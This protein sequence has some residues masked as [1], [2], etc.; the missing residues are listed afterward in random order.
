MGETCGW[1]GKILRVDLST[2]SVTTEDTSKYVPDYIGGKGIATKIAW[3]ELK[4]GVGP[5]DPENILIFMTGPFAGTLAPTSGRGIV[6]GVSPRPYPTPWFTYGGIGGN[7]ASELKYAGFDGMAIKGNSSKPVYLWVHDGEAEIKEAEALWGTDT[8]FT[9]KS[10][11][12]EYGKKAQVLCIGPAGENRV[13]FATI[14]HRLSNAVGNAGLGAV[15]GAKKLKGIVIRGTGGVKVANPSKFL[16]ACQ[17]VTELISAGPTFKPIGSPPGP[18]SMPCTHACPLGCSAMFKN[19]PV[20]LEVGS[21]TRTMMGHCVNSMYNLGINQTEYPIKFTKDSY[22]GD[23]HTR[24]TKGFGIKIGTELQVIGEGLGL[25]GWNYL[26]MYVWFWSCIDNGVTELNGYKLDP[27]NPEFWH[28]LLHKIAYREG[29]GDILADSLRRA[30]DRLDLPEIIRKHASWQEPIWGFSTH[31]LGRGFEWQPSP[32]WIYTM[33]Q[34]IMD[35]RDP[36][37][38]NHQSSFVEFW[39]PPHYGRGSPDTDFDKLK[40]TYAR[41]FGSGEV[42]EPGFGDIDGKTKAA[43]WLNNR[44]QLKD[45][46][47]LCDWC[48]PRVLSGFKSKEELKAAKDYYGDIDAEAKLFGPLTGLD[49]STSD[50]EKA[51]ERIKNL[52]RALH[53]RNYN[54]S[55]KIDSSAEWLFEYPEKSDGTKLDMAIFDT[56]LDSYYENRGWDKTTGC[57]TRAKLEELGLKDVADKLDNLG[58]LP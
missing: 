11:K 29:I 5:Y 33:L 36:M 26:N 56:I 47:L 43:I 58:K 53:I 10:L 41:V 16:S 45:S 31:R 42:I 30:C 54:R 12:A 57:P 3:D 27:D 4:P 2:D 55:R 37:A 20:G 51:G 44:A 9:Q 23:I 46:L 13:L 8:Y 32:I 7:W 49:I 22:T 15:M 34:W 1:A 38:S 14:Q 35:S 39:F 25:S 50:L 52:D 21:G 6:C 24:A 40:A 48:F 28:D 17:E 19:I 18:E